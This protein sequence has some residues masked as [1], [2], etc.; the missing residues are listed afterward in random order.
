MLVTLRGHPTAARE[1]FGVGRKNAERV[2][3]LL[4]DKP[5]WQNCEEYEL[6]E[7]GGHGN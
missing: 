7:G 3:H 4:F 2:E 6:E 1:G 5:L